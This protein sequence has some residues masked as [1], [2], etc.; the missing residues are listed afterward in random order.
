MTDSDF[1]FWAFLSYSAEDNGAGCAGAADPE[2]FGWGDWLHAA[3]KNFSIPAEFIGQINA[4]GEIIPPSI[5]PIFQDEHAYDNESGLDAGAQAALEQSRYLVVICSPRA[6]KSGRV[7]EA[8]QFFKQRG[9]GQHILPFVVAGEPH[10]GE[11]GRTV[12]SA[13]D[14]CLVPALRHPLSADGELDTSR[15]ASKFIFVDARHGLDKQEITLRHDLSCEA[16]LEM[17]K[18]QLIAEVIGVAFN[19]LWSREQRRHFMDLAKMRREVA[20]ARQQVE[21]ARRELQAARQANHEAQNKILAAQDLPDDVHNQIQNAQTRTRAAED[22]TRDAQQQLEQFQSRL[23]NTEGQLEEARQR[24]LTAEGKFLE[25]QNQSRVWQRQA[26]TLRQQFLEANSQRRAAQEKT[27]PAPDAPANASSQLEEAP[28]KVHAAETNARE[29]QRQ[30]EELKKQISSAPVPVASPAPQTSS[31]RLTQVLAVMAV[32]ALMGAATAT[33]VAWS[34][35][36]V[37]KQVLA[38]VATDSVWEPDF[39]KAKMDQEQIRSALELITGVKCAAIRPL[40]LDRL[41]TWIPKA[42]IGVALESAAIISDDAQRSHFQKLLL[43]RLGWANPQAAMTQASAIHEKIVDAQGGE[44]DCG[45]FQL[46]VLDNWMKKDLPAAFNW[47]CQ[48]PETNLRDRALMKII[49][50]IVAANPANALVRLENLS[51]APA[52]NIFA[53]FFQ[54]WA[55]LEPVTAIQEWQRISER[56]QTRSF[57]ISGAPT[58]LR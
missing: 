42:E 13:A 56:E 32:L 36:K 29:A 18:I 37:A 11:T 24:L 14:E 44:A 25:S 50:A 10:A 17:A 3:L 16:D 1:K 4:R 58:S 6:A 2:S 49:P 47:I 41:A 52:E 54:C 34:Q 26:E 57:S 12:I 39:S 27:T 23:R 43:I 53:I 21:Q 15:R 38:E 51:P 48:Q 5:S 8:V 45:Y 55:A 40:S 33:G 46:A 22:Q 20:E 19:G 35:R 28:A 30:L 7:N 31:Q 9:R